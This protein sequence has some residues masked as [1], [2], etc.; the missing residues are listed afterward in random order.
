[1]QGFQQIDR[2]DPAFKNKPLNHR[3]VVHGDQRLQTLPGDEVTV[4]REVLA[5]RADLHQCDQEHPYPA[6]G[7]RM[8]PEM[9]IHE[10]DP[11]IRFH[12]TPALQQNGGSQPGR[13]FMQAQILMVNL[14]VSSKR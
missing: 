14:I 2:C 3:E 6:C 9:M 12:N 10:H 4:I 7:K 5:P 1:M 11:A 8:R 13:H